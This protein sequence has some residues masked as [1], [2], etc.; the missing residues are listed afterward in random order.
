[1]LLSL[2]AQHQ[3]MVS[4]TEKYTGGVWFWVL[5]P[6]LFKLS[7]RDAVKLQRSCCVHKYLLISEVN[8]LSISNRSQ[9]ASFNWYR[10]YNDKWKP[11]NIH[12]F[13]KVAGKIEIYQKRNINI[14]LY[15]CSTSFYTQAQNNELCMHASSSACY[16]WV[17]LAFKVTQADW[18]MII[19]PLTPVS[20]SV[21]TWAPEKSSTIKPLYKQPTNQPAS[22]AYHSVTNTTAGDFVSQYVLML[23]HPRTITNGLSKVNH[24]GCRFSLTQWSLSSHRTDKSA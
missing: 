5:S 8:L 6:I 7:V 14:S 9:K 20:H 4:I 12:P 17:R 22:W 13:K 10:W 3:E 23:V 15:L 1:M 24:P 2:L 11:F 16:N 19:C 18:V 21:R